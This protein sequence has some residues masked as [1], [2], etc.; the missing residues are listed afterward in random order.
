MNEIINF[1]AADMPDNTVIFSED[2]QP[3][4]SIMKPARLFYVG[5]HKGRDYTKPDLAR[6]VQNFNP[7][8]EIPLQLDHSKSARDTIGFPRKV[9]LSEDGTEIHGDLEFRGKDNV[10]KVRLGLWKKLSIGLL[11]GWNA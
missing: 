6:I 5:K 3:G 7:D 1:T 11:K 9:W 2:I 4:E 10:E 8:E